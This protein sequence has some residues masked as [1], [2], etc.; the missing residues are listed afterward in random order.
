MEASKLLPMDDLKL[1]GIYRN[2]NFTIPEEQVRALKNGGIT[3]IIALKD[4]KSKERDIHI[5]K[6]PARL[7]IGKGDDG[8]PSLRI[9]PV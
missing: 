5:E 8:K 1:F 6:L 2:G 3:D 7:S 4:L 9:D